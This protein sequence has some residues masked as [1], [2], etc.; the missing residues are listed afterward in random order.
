M[1]LIHC[2]YLYF[3]LRKNYV[4]EKTVSSVLS[5]AAQARS[6]YSSLD[7]YLK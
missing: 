1:T 2:L 6:L 7:V 5:R 4:H 3:S